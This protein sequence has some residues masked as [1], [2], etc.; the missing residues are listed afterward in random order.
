MLE[1]FNLL[2][3]STM[4]QKNLIQNKGIRTITIGLL[5]L[6]IFALLYLRKNIIDNKILIIGIVF[7]FVGIIT[8]VIK[9]EKAEITD[10]LFLKINAVSL[11]IICR[12]QILL[13]TVLYLIN[14]RWQTLPF[15]LDEILAGF[16][17][18]SIALHLCISRRYRTHTEKLPF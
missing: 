4:K 7:L 11:M 18:G 6:T 2:F 3:F 17:Y 12:I 13:V 9:R 10:E 15:T 1:I 8:Y 5:L 16:L 14:T